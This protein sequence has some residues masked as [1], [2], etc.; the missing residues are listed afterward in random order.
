MPLCGTDNRLSGTDR[1]ASPSWLLG[2]RQMITRI[3]ALLGN[4]VL[5]ACY[6]FA[7]FFLGLLVYAATQ[8]EAHEVTTWVVTLA[9]CAAA[10]VMGHT[11][12]YILGGNRRSIPRRGLALRSRL[13]RARQWDSTDANG[14]R[15][16]VHD[17][18]K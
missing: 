16:A 3:L 4:V 18:R 10:I 7:A 5:F 12:R 9:V 2:E 17:R 8:H 11:I 6:A 1:V 15:E 14:D 13:L